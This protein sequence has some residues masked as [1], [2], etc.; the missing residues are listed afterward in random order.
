MAERLSQVGA[1][2]RL[3]G[4]LLGEGIHEQHGAGAFA[5]V[6]RVCAQAR[7]RREHATDTTPTLGRAATLDPL[8]WTSTACSSKRAV[9]TA[10]GSL[11]LRINSR[12]AFYSTVKPL[13]LG[14]IAE[15]LPT[16]LR[17]PAWLEAMRQRAETSHR[18]YRACVY[19]ISGFLDY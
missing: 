10:S 5:L 15:C 13:G 2:S 16:L 9:T 17:P 14:R 4:K 8:T 11:L 19:E 7:S 3:S 6:E 1:A 12:C 18:A